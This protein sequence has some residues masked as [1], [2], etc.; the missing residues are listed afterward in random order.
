[1]PR[2]ASILV[3]RGKP[4]ADAAAEHVRKIVEKHGKLAGICDADDSPLPTAAA[5]ADLFI[6]LGGDG[7]LLGQ[8]R[9]TINHDAPMLGVNFGKLG[10]MAEFDLQSFEQQAPTLLNASNELPTQS[11]PILAATIQRARS[12]AEP[13]SA[14]ALNDVVVTAGPPY[15]MITIDISIDNNAG[16]TIDGDG[17]IISTPIGSTAYNVSAGGAIIAPATQAL[18]ITPIA[19][20]SLAFRSVVL[21]LQHTIHL[22][23]RNV[24]RQSEAG[25]TTMVVDGQIHTPIEQN[26]RITIKTHHKTANFVRNTQSNYWHTLINKLHWAARPATLPQTQPGSKDH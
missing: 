24:N 10:F 22:T 26:D 17:L 23:M 19:A 4:D 12:N 6:V 13:F 9:R 5:N 14:T 11:L 25:G 15:R 7:T 3:N 20:H 8:T 2:S 18:A 21:P 1:M 16:P